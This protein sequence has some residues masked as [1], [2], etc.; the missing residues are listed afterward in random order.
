MSNDL[1]FDR[2][3]GFARALIRTPSPPGREEKVARQV[4]AELKALGFQDVRSDAVGNVVGVARGRGE[5]PPV[6]L[7]SHLDVVDVGEEDAWEYP[8]FAADVA[9]GFLHG[10]G[11]MDIKGPLAVQTYA[12]ARYL[13]YPAAGSVIV[14]HTVLEERGGWGME[15][16][17]EAAEVAPGA[18]I[19]GE[20]TNLDVCI[21]HRGRAELIVEITGVAGHA[22]APGRARNPLY[23]F[24]T[25]LPALEAFAAELEE[26]P[27]LG[28]ATLAPTEATTLPASR[29]V[30][31]DRAR[32][33]LDWRVLP[34]LNAEDAAQRVESYLHEHA[35]LPEGCALTV[36][37]ATERQHTWTDRQEE[38]RLF[39]PGYL[40]APDHA[41]VRAAASAVEAATGRRPETR[42]WTFATDGGHTCGVAGIPT[43]GFA[44]GEERHAHTNRERLELAQMRTA[45]DAHPALIEAVM[46]ALR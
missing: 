31:P 41:V 32:L 10:R 13:E 16:L 34:G 29:N 18:V 24:S 35:S 40:L 43:I 44:P 33:V 6:M 14:A 7:S 37:C 12:A 5:A 22:S 15:H 46:G 30:I 36:R 2:M 28:R 21:G 17:I 4:L 45:Y 3:L 38:R 11:A 9:D 42:P 26:D 19:L 27:V 8:P 1:S 20:A 23:A 25:V 39:T